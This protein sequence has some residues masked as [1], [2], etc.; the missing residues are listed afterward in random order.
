MYL[1]VGNKHSS[2]Q[3]IRSGQQVASWKSI[4]MQCGE[5]TKDNNAHCMLIIMISS[6]QMHE[7]TFS[8]LYFLLL[9]IVI[10]LSMNTYAGLLFSSAS[11]LQMGAG[12]Q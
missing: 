9:V 1:C 3:S 12:F 10:L 6:P 2:A 7:A 4:S 11:F 5:E 8:P